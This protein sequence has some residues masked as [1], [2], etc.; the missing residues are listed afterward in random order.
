MTAPRRSRRPQAR[1]IAPYLFL[2][3][4]MAIFLVF[5][6]YPAFNGFNISLYD[7]NNGRTFT[8]VGLANYER[9]L[10]DDE[11][12]GVAQQTVIFAVG[13]VGLSVVGSIILAVLLDAQRRARSFFRAVVFVP[14]LLSPV[15]VGLLWRWL[16]DRQDGLVNVGLGGV[17]LPQPGWL[18]DPTLALGA[19]VLV[20]VWTNVG[21]YT[22]ILL[23]GL[24]GIDRDVYEAASLDGATGWDTF[25]RITLPLLAP[26]TLVVV[27]L[28]VI[29]GLQAFDY[30][31]SLTGGGPIGATTLMV[32][33]I[34]ERGFQSPVRYGLAAAGSVVL[35]VTVFGFTVLNWLLG[36]R[37][38]NS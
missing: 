29:N 34:Y 13:F 8:P 12:L 28:S 31:Y 38:E 14:V 9:I 16:L 15:V 3:P 11:F 37:R 4:N 1:Q 10:T 23:A 19:V 33:Y 7:S 17:G 27:I 5:T 21:F 26:T 36:R 20:G 25:R 32:Q 22:L 18:V 30:I 35:F 24:Q 2:L 6:I